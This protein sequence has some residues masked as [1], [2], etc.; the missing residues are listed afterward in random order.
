[1][2]QE[3]I[4]YLLVRFLTHL[5]LMTEICKWSNNTFV[6]LT[7][8]TKICYD[9]MLEFKFMWSHTCY[10]GE[11]REW[12]WEKL[13]GCDLPK[14]DVAS[15]EISCDC[16]TVDTIIVIIPSPALWLLSLFWTSM[17]PGLSSHWISPMLLQSF[18]VGVVA[19]CPPFPSLELLRLNLIDLNL[20]ILIAFWISFSWKNWKC[21]KR[22][23][24]SWGRYIILESVHKDEENHE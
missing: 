1:M 15:I 18:S 4:S 7:I 14:V 5:M 17:P 20:I 22:S 9:I 8:I 10:F 19:L 12:L 3:N 23:W 24:S 11:I 6:N 2:I 16:E 21:S 13:K